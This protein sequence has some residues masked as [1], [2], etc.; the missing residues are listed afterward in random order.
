MNFQ[1]IYL[2]KRATHYNNENEIWDRHVTLYVSVARNYG[3]LN[4]YPSEVILFLTQTPLLGLVLPQSPS[5]IV[6][7]YFICTYIY[8]QRSAQNP[9]LF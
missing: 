7:K 5:D 4:D 3:N 1:V 6:D 8:Q 2:N 9:E